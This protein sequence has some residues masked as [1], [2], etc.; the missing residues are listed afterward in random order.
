MASAGSF[1]H[2]TGASEERVRQS[3]EEQDIAD[4]ISSIDDTTSVGSSTTSVLR[5]GR[6][7]AGDGGGIFLGLL[8]PPALQQVT[9]TSAAGE[10]V[11]DDGKAIADAFPADWLNDFEGLGLDVQDR[12]ASSA[13]P[14]TA[15]AQPIRSSPPG[16]QPQQQQ[17]QQQIEDDQQQHRDATIPKNETGEVLGEEPEILDNVDEGYGSGAAAAGMLMSAGGRMVSWAANTPASLVDAA[18]GAFRGDA[19]HA[20]SRNAGGDLG[21]GSAAAAST[22]ADEL[23]LDWQGTLDMVGMAEAETDT[24][25]T[26]ALAAAPVSELPSLPPPAAREGGFPDF[27]EIRDPRNV[28][29][30]PKPDNALVAKSAAGRRGDGQVG[31]GAGDSG[32]HAAAGQEHGQ[33]QV[34]PAPL[35]T[36]EVYLRPDVTW[37]SVSD[38]Y[39][40]VMLSR[41]LVVRHQTEKMVTAEKSADAPGDWATVKLTVGV[42]RDKLR[43]LVIQFYAGTRK[44]APMLS[45]A[46]T[47]ARFSGRTGDDLYT[48]IRDVLVERQM[49]LSFLATDAEEVSLDP[50]Y[51][52]DLVGMYAHENVVNLTRYALPLEEFVRQEEERLAR[53]EA[54]LLP[55]Y[56]AYGLAPPRPT[57]SK[58]LSAYP[59][60]TRR[61]PVSACGVEEAREVVERAREHVRGGGGSSHPPQKGVDVDD[62]NVFASGGGGSGEGGEG[63]GAGEGSGSSSSVAEGIRSLIRATWEDVKEW[64]DEE[65]EARV[66]RKDAQVRDRLLAVERHREALIAALRDGAGGSAASSTPA[67]REFAARF[68]PLA[69]EAVLCECKAVHAKRVGQLY[70]TCNHVCFHSS[71]L[72]FTSQRVLPLLTVATITHASSVLGMDLLTLVDRGGEEH[73]FGITAVEAGFPERFHDLLKQCLVLCKADASR[74]AAQREGAAATEPDEEQI[75]ARVQRLAKAKQLREAR[76]A[77]SAAASRATAATPTAA[78]AVDMAPPAASP[79]SRSG[80]P[81]PEESEVAKR[82]TGASVGG[83]V[84]QGGPGGAMGAGGG[85]AATEAGNEGSG[86]GQDE[87]AGRGARGGGRSGSMMAM[88]IQAFLEESQKRS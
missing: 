52:R 60:T 50:H 81:R 80:F 4:F 85:S 75:L 2:G 78:G 63:R 42:T 1:V 51:V 5:G 33:R 34:L 36:V 32:E 44:Q 25:G 28:S 37:E 12:T 23:P 68:R 11:S 39:M 41:G 47:I 24:K 8:S 62:E 31:Q 54:T 57:R 53:L 20:V 45:L 22:D 77:A 27:V 35:R 40:G 17:Q 69:K 76:E 56:R 43:T 3:K 16:Q 65:A 83:G 79:H 74:R 84:V 19:H 82:D 59:L 48:A 18:T 55:Q 72:G 66:R 13:A 46:G 73:S 61:P 10:L 29:Q 6:S 64:C 49:P 21:N 15:A 30:F 86:G 88:G 70:L 9:G 38:V 87:G 67:G 58:P 26:S 71:V 7:S 14:A